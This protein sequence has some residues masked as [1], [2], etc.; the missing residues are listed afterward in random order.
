MLEGETA[1]Q[2]GKRQLGGHGGDSSGFSRH[3]VADGAQGGVLQWEVG[4]CVAKDWI[5]H[6]QCNVMEILAVHTSE[7]QALNT[8]HACV[9]AIVW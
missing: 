7:R 3:A 9:G 2:R 1:E 5:S 6:S 4:H 8:T